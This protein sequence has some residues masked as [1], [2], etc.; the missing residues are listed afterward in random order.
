MKFALGALFLVAHLRTP[1]IATSTKAGQ[2]SLVS[3]TK[4][5]DSYRL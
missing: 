1:A 5:A 4:Q 2:A 3:A